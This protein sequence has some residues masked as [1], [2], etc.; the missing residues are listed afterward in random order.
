MGW[1]L[2]YYCTTFCNFHH[3]VRDGKPMEHECYILP[4]AA[5]RA[6]IAGDYVTSIEILMVELP[7]RRRI[8][9][10]GVKWPKET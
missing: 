7:H 3:R 9:R 2:S 10:R 4:P 8:M 6:E 5:L 1:A